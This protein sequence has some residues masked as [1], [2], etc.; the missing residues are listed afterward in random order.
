MKRGIY[1][2]SFDPATRGHLDVIRRASLIVD[3]LH[4]MIGVNPKKSGGF[5]PVAKRLELIEGSL[6]HMKWFGR[7]RSAFRIGQFT[8]LLVDYCRQHDIR[9]NIRGLRAAQDFNYEFEMHGINCDIAP[10]IN[11]VFLIAPPESSSSSAAPSGNSPATGRPPSPST[12][13]RAW[14]PRC[15][16]RI[17]WPSLRL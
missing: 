8:G 3:E 1:A 7:E 9:F 17:E 11:T 16:T 6:A 13:L 2:G 14:S 12:S 10:E 5:F 4:V 15:S